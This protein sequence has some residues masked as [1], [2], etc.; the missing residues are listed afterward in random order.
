MFNNLRETIKGLNANVNNVANSEKATKLRKK[1]LSIGLTLAILGFLGVFVCFA[2]FAISSFNAVNTNAFSTGIIVPCL[3]IFPFGIM[4]SI[5]AVIASLGFQI[6][7]T[8]YATNLIDETVGNNCPN[9][10]KTID[11][12]MQFCANCGTELKKECP[13][14][15]ASNDNQNEYCSKCGTKL[16]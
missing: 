13:N 9:C 14:C 15:K 5:G 6:V 2:I 16:N 3:L 8:G 4:G 12:D 11:S 10:V 1:L 7:I